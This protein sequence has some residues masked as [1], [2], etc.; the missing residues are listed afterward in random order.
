MND[1]EATRRHHL[2]AYQI[3]GGLYVVHPKRETLLQ[4]A[5][6]TRNPRAIAAHDYVVWNRTIDSVHVDTDGLIA[7]QHP[8][9]GV[10]TRL[11]GANWLDEPVALFDEPKRLTYGDVDELLAAD[12]GDPDA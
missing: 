2:P 9:A 7:I 6:R 5:G 8:V 4:F 10:E 12:G 1:V 3:N 11:A